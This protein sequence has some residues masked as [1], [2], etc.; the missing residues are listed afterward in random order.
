M[1]QT[2][3]KLGE[4]VIYYFIFCYKGTFGEVYKGVRTDTG[5]VVAMKKIRIRKYQDGIPKAVFR[6]I[7][8]MQLLDHE[9]VFSSSLYFLILATE[10]L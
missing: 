1:Y 9:N 4:G 5:E 7:Q 2:V 10:M 6:E 3:N 8:A